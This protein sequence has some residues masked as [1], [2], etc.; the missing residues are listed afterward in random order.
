MWRNAID[1]PVKGV[2]KGGFVMWDSGSIHTGLAEHT[3]CN[4]PQRVTCN[5]QAFD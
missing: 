2:E 1:E 3:R 5:L 4:I